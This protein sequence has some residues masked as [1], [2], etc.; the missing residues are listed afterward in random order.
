M[1]LP[2]FI[3]RELGSIEKNA[4]V[5]PSI[6][7]YYIAAWAFWLVAI[8]MANIYQLTAATLIQWDTKPKARLYPRLQFWV[9]VLSLLAGFVACAFGAHQTFKV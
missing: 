6:N 8:V 3:I 5:G 7:N 9:M 4:S 1:F 2:V